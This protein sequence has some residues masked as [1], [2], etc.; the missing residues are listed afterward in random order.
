MKKDGAWKMD[1]QNKECTC[2]RKRQIRKNNA[3]IDI[4]EEKK[5]TG[6]LAKKE[7][8][9][10]GCSRRNGKREEGSRQKKISNDRSINHSVLSEGKSF[11]ANSTF[12]TLPS[13]QP[14]FSYLHTFW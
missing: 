12:S 2:A 8:P 6:P 5:L 7:L 3:G 11:T 1:R 9:D 13:S 10:E 4:E 14:S